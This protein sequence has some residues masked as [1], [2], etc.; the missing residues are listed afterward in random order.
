MEQLAVGLMIADPELSAQLVRALEGL[1]VRI[2]MEMR[3]VAAAEEALIERE[4]I[5]SDPDV[6]FVDIAA[7]GE[8]FPDLLRLVKGRTFPPAIV[9]VLR[10]ADAEVLLWA[11]RTGASDCLYPPFQE[12]DL[13]QVVERIAEDRC[14]THPQRLSS[15]AVGFLSA[16]GGCGGTTLACHFAEEL[17]RISGQSLLLADF[18]ITAGMVGFWMHSTDGYS[19]WDAIRSLQ[20]LDFSMW[21][22]LVTAVQDQFDV[23]S[24]PSEILTDDSCDA[25]KLLKILRFARSHYDWVVADLGPGLTVPSLK[26]LGELNALFVVSTPEVATL[27]QCRRLLQKLMSLGY[28]RHR[29][30]LVLNRVEKRQQLQPAEVGEALGWRVEAALPDDLLEVELAQEENRLVS[31]RSDLGRRIAQLT[32]NF[33]TGK[34]EEAEG[35]KIP[36]SGVPRPAKALTKATY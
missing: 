33:S 21:R 31:R 18:D 4:V 6:L 32:V 19:I 15:R 29:I 30:R 23:L 28:P 2:V 16:T 14:R 10:K 27:Y 5:R 7:V 22:G 26:L 1:S 35:L 25:E 20:R 13:R 3:D 11:M 34:W 36:A 12:A 24:A 17:R 8:R 9:G